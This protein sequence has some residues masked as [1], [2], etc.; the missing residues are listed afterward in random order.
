M[1]TQSILRLAIVAVL[2]LGFASTGLATLASFQGLGAGT[3][4]YDVSANGR[5]V[6]GGNGTQVFRW[7]VTEGIQN[8][9]AGVARSVSA[10]GSVVAGDSYGEAFQ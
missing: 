1:K 7:T 2:L 3:K 6:A 8:L 4:A 5:V 10:D 9:G